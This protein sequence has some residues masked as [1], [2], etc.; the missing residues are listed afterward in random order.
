M[1][2]QSEFTYGREVAPVPALDANA[3][4]WQRFIFERD[5][6]CGAHAEWWHH[7]NGCRQWLDIVRDTMTHEVL[8]IKVARPPVGANDAG[9]GATAAATAGVDTPASERAPQMQRP[10]E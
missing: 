1:R 7:N 9:A 6:P 5:N 4:E 10:S 2:D 8:Q 3:A